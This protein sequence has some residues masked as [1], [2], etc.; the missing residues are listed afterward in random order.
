M[1]NLTVTRI[2]MSFAD[3]AEIRNCARNGGAKFVNRLVVAEVQ[4]ECQPWV[5]NSHNSSC[6]KHQVLSTRDGASDGPERWRNLCA[7]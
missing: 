4:C 1:A 3:C 2:A 6:T 5:E 7:T